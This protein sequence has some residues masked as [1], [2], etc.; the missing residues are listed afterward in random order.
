MAKP[1][2]SDSMISAAA[3]RSASRYRTSDGQ[4]TETLWD[5]TDTHA[6]PNSIGPRRLNHFGHSRASLL[7]VPALREWRH[8]G[9]LEHP[10]C[11]PAFQRVTR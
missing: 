3:F 6:L 1:T 7:S 4:T 9:L 5:E 8:R 11:W 10:L 2:L